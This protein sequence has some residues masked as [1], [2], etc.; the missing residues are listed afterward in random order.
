MNEPPP[1]KGLIIGL[2]RDYIGLMEEKVA[3]TMINKP[4]PSTGDPYHNPCYGEGVLN[5]GTGLV[6]I[7][8][9]AVST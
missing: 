2:F 8:Y 7:L 1:F 6:S 5:Q 3:I 9:C 4:H